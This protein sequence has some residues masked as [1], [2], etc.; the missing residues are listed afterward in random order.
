MKDE[1]YTNKENALQ[2][3]IIN[4]L[5]KQTGKLLQYLDDNNIV[6]TNKDKQYILD[7]NE[8]CLLYAGS[9]PDEE[10]L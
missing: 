2:E 5:L 3:L 10:E 1:S 9:L 8:L 4:R 7:T 6:I